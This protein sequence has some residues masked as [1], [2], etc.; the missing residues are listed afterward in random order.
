MQYKVFVAQLGHLPPNNGFPNTSNGLIFRGHSG[1]VDLRC[2][3]KQILK[4]FTSFTGKHL[5]LSLLP[6]VTLLKRDSNTGVFLWNLRNLLEHIFVQIRWLLLGT[7]I[8][9]NRN[10][11]EKC[12]VLQWSGRD[13]TWR[14]LFSRSSRI[15]K[16]EALG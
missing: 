14:G 2:S 13:H 5:C 11:L 10:L 4:N 9:G 8:H 6:C 7:G 16:T 12:V 1:A 3:S 15:W